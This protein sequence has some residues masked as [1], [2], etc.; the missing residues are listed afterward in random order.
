[1]RASRD[2]EPLIQGFL[3]E[4]TDKLPVRVYDE[5]RAGIER[6][7]QR[8]VIGR[9]PLPAA[10]PAWFAIAAAVVVGIA[11]G[12][13][14]L[15][16][17]AQA[18]GEVRIGSSWLHPDTV[19]FVATLP[20]ETPADLYWR[21][22][23][24]DRF[25]LTSWSQSNATSRRVEAGQPLLTG[26]GDLP[27]G[28][29]D[30]SVTIMPSHGGMDALLAPG[31]PILVDRAADIVTI[32]GSG[33]IAQGTL[34]GD[35][36]YRV[37]ASVLDPGNGQITGREL[38]G[39]STD[40]PEDVR[41]RYTG[42]PAGALGPQAT[43]LLHEILANA[44]TRNPYRLA[45]AIEVY[46]RDPAHF[47]YATDLRNVA[48]NEASA[49]ECFVQTREG[50]CLHYAS[51]M[52]ILLRAANPDD[53]I[54]TRLVQGFLPGTRSGTTETV[55]DRNAHVWVEVYFPGYGWIPFDPTG[56]NVAVLPAI[57]EG[58]PVTPETEAPSSEQP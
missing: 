15:P 40:Y 54:P 53:P 50:Y 46:L 58:S 34:A 33:W 22:A 16:A 28:E 42:V 12:G 45:V 41:S 25:D 24:Y 9:W 32:G 49:V 48:C 7:R 5:V 6:T 39:A 21:A 47:T 57:P 17:T 1:M 52:A 37:T 27:V 36:P 35:G 4:G 30:L 23:T 56:G 38:E 43:A 8:P 2:P 20:S 14:L 44:G 51:T 13:S 55:Q 31:I 10:G 3:A 18:G 26:H 19:A 29:T 11:V